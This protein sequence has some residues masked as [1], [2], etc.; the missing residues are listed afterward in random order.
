MQ[1]YLILDILFKDKL[2][3]RTVDLNNQLDYFYTSAQIGLSVLIFICLIYVFWISTLIS[4]NIEIPINKLITI[5]KE[6]HLDPN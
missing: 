4:R 6:M 5:F 1:V 3:E 2:M